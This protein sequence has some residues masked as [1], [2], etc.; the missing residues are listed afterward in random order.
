MKLKILPSHLKSTNLKGEP[1]N[2]PKGKHDLNSLSIY[3]FDTKVELQAVVVD[4]E[5]M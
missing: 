4:E 3:L 1:T 5:T 2:E